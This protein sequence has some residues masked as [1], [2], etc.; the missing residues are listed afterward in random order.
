MFAPTRNT[1]RVGNLFVCFA[2][3]LARTSPSLSHGG[4]EHSNSSSAISHASVA[5]R[6]SCG[7]D[8]SLQCHVFQ[9]EAKVLD[10]L[11]ASRTSSTGPRAARHAVRHF[12]KH[13]LTLLA[14]RPQPVWHGPQAESGKV[15]DSTGPPPRI[16]HSGGLSH[17]DAARLPYCGHDGRRPTGLEPDPRRGSGPVGRRCTVPPRAAARRTEKELNRHDR[18][19]V[20]RVLAAEIDGAVDGAAIRSP[21]HDAQ[22]NPTAEVR[23]WLALHRVW[24][25][26][27]WGEKEIVWVSVTEDYG[28]DSGNTPA[29]G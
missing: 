27:V 23:A 7:G 16:R 18:W 10:R 13:P 19:V 20:L 4:R 29:Q 14:G 25:H 6:S 3:S 21:A 17:V 26:H 24:D 5:S 12:D 22:K 9:V 15:A 1:S 8:D 11:S 2:Y 28:D